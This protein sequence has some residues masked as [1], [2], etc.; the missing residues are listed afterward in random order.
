MFVIDSLKPNFLENF[1]Q[2][3]TAY[4]AFIYQDLLKNENMNRSLLKYD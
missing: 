3:F 4:Y 1:F 2:K